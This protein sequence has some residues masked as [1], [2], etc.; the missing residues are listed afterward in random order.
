MEKNSRE[1]LAERMRPKDLDSFIGQRQLLGKGKPLRLIIDSGYLPSLILWGPPGCGK[2]SLA[3]ILAELFNYSFHSFSAVVSGI[4]ELKELFLRL[5]RET[6]HKNIVFIDEIHRFNKA[7]QDAFLPYVERGV[8]TLI[9][10][11]TLNPS[12]S[13][14]SPLLSRMKVLVLK[15]LKDDE[16]TEL[17]RKALTDKINGYGDLKIKYSEEI[18]SVIASYSEGDGRAALNMLE[19]LV[20][21]EMAEGDTPAAEMLAVELSESAGGR[22]NREITLELERL[23]E[24][25]QG[26]VPDYDRDGEAHY[27]LISALHKSIR[28]SDPDAALYWLARMLEGGEDP[29]YIARRLIRVAMED[30]GLADPNALSIAVNAKE[31]LHFMGMPEGDLALAETVIYLATAPKS[32]AVY[33]A[34]S[35][36]KKDA[37]EYASTPVP[38]Y[39][40]NPVTS[41]MRKAGYGKGYMYPHDYPNRVVAQDYFPEKMGKRKYY[42]PTGYGYEKTLSRRIEW[43]QEKKGKS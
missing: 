30:V 26:K 40:R 4:R 6:S 14:V 13:I 38:L 22:E 7:Q 31:A 34:Y 23:K 20:E 35:K 10:T 17:L 1:P 37:M 9:G 32:N 8:I 43:W 36:A 33:T 3:R 11:T 18:L 41:V 27:N 12:F 21:S 16:I 29:L 28:G 24:L 5:E 2:T 25:F 39:L 15:G 19:M 42:N